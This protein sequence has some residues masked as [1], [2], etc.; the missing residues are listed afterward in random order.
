MKPDPADIP[1]MEQVADG[2][3]VRQAI[4]N[5]G[6]VDMGGFAV[7]VDALEQRELEEEVFRAIGETIGD[8]PVRYVFNTHTHYDHVALNGAFKRRLGSEI[9]NRRTCKIPPEGRWYK[10]QRRRALLLP[11]PG[12]HTKD[13]CVVW[14]PEDRA[15][16][17]GDIFGWGLISLTG[18]LNEKTERLLLETHQKLIDL[19]P[20]VVI[21]G[22]GPLCSVN[23]LERWVKYFCWLRDEV[24]RAVDTGLTDKEIKHTLAPPEDMKCWWRLVQ[25]KHE[26]SVARVIKAV[27]GGWAARQGA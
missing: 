2:F 7:V 10:G 15:L 19:G 13:D 5:I 1:S 6:W 24:A 27:R 21:P 3:F 23:E 18:H 8:V 11:M 20:A 14:V 9:I 17:V 26:D 16:F 4:D 22:H 25:W 12:C